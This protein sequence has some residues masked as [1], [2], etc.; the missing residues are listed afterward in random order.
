MYLL[1]RNKQSISLSLANFTVHIKYYS[2]YFESSFP[3]RVAD[4]NKNKVI[5]QTLHKSCIQTKHLT[6]FS[7]KEKQLKP[8]IQLSTKSEKSLKT[9]AIVNKIEELF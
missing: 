4:T 6:A 5:I 2:Y 1:R 7:I 9:N 3:K 8:T